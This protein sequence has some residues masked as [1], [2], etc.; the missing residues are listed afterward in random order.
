[1]NRDFF[2]GLDKWQALAGDI[3]LKPTLIYGGSKTYQHKAVEVISWKES[4]TLF[5]TS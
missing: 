1:M 2:A 3:V 4:G 5:V